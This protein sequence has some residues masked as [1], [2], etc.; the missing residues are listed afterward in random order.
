MINYV[1]RT[2][3]MIPTEAPPKTTATPSKSIDITKTSDVK[4][5]LP[6]AKLTEEGKQGTYS[7]AI[8]AAKI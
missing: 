7:N 6:S 2:Q 5:S 3:K 8:V 1:Y 4:L